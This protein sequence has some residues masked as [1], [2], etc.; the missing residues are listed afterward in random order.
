MYCGFE[1]IKNRLI[2]LKYKKREPFHYKFELISIPKHGHTL[3]DYDIF[4][5]GY[6]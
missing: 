3:F 2:Y 6:V 5:F 4:G 1:V